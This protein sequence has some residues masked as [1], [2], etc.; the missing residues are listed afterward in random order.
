MQIDAVDRVVAEI[1]HGEG[2]QSSVRT[3]DRALISARGGEDLRWDQSRRRSVH[4]AAPWHGLPGMAIDAVPL[5]PIV[6][7]AERIT[8]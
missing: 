1:A 8:R 6:L 3:D 7:I 2:I 4:M 5:R